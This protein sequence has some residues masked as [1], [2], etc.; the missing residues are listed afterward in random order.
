[1]SLTDEQLKAMWRSTQGSPPLELDGQL[2]FQLRTAQRL[3]SYAGLIADAIVT[4]SAE[5]EER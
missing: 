5:L 4:K 3:F 2:L 1:M